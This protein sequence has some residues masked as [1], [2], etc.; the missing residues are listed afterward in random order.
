MAGVNLL[1]PDYASIPMIHA[2]LRL[3]PTQTALGRSAFP[4][5]F[6]RQAN[7]RQKCCFQWPRQKPYSAA[8]H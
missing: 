7:R 1:I 2:L 6:S 5:A 4:I 8:D 3:P